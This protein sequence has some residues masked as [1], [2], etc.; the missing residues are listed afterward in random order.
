MFVVANF[1]LIYNNLFFHNFLGNRCGSDRMV[2]GFIAT[3]A[4]SVYHH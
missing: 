1:I 2:V 3:S 4:I